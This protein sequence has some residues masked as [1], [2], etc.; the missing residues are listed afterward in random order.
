[1]V[2]MIPALRLTPVKAKHNGRRIHCDHAAGHRKLLYIGVLRGHMIASGRHIIFPALDVLQCHPDPSRSA[3]TQPAVDV[4]AGR[5]GGIG[6]G[7]RGCVDAPPGT[8]HAA[9]GRGALKL[10]NP[11]SVRRRALG[12]D[13]HARQGEPRGGGNDA[14]LG[15]GRARSRASAGRLGGKMQP[16]GAAAAGWRTRAGATGSQP[17]RSPR[18]P[19]AHPNGPKGR[20]AGGTED[21]EGCRKSLARTAPGRSR[22]RFLVL[23]ALAGSGSGSDAGLPEIAAGIAAAHHEVGSA[24]PGGLPPNERM[25]ELGRGV[26]LAA[27]DME[28]AGL[29]QL[30]AGGRMQIT[31]SGGALLGKIGEMAGGPGSAGAPTQKGSAA[32]GGKA[33][34]AISD[35]FLRELSPAYREWQDGGPEAR[36]PRRGAGGDAKMSS[37][38][39]AAIDM[40]GTAK[41]WKTRDL[42]ELQRLW[43]E[44]SGLAERVLRPEDGFAV[45][46]ESDAIKVTGSGHSTADLLRAFGGSSWRIVVKGLQIGVPMRGCVAAGEYC[47]GPRELVMGRAVDRAKEWHDRAQW[48]GIAA[49]PSAGS[50]LDEIVRA[51]AAGADPV[52]R[53]YA[54]YDIP[55]KSGTDAGWAVNW[56]RQCEETGT[57]GGAAGMMRII[58]DSQK[59]APDE[60]AA[61][62]WA[63]T[64]KFCD[65]MIRG[66]DPISG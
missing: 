43:D 35:S 12:V 50:V 64:G 44:L 58:R 20:A 16:G 18:S 39:V 59:K 8:E 13:G 56:P 49:A 15:E 19:A 55:S 24:A 30:G 3:R 48:I 27:G 21:H 36:A 47:T 34:P 54:M 61:L 33:E 40:L 5:Q 1:M 65:D 60:S 57:G 2:R 14:G 45:T 32:G 10:E 66:W 52:R 6:M 53:R 38:I 4:I 25:L 7:V 28:H 41:A 62:K 23:E 51:D 17:A 29:V 22:L 37:G 42:P 9:E 26:K 11:G 31:A 63:N 46:T